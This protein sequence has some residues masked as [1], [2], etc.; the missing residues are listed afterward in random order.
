MSVDKRI[1][2]ICGHRKSGT[3]MFVNLFDGHPELAVFPQDAT[4]LYAYH[5]RWL[6]ETYSDRDRRERLEQV[7]CRFFTVN[8]AREC[9]ASGFDAN[10]FAARF[11]AALP[12]SSLRDM[13]A[14][15]N[16]L[17]DAYG[18]TA[19]NAERRWFVLKET[20]VELMAAELFA[21]F[22]NSRFIQLMRDPRDNYGALKSGVEK[23]YGRFGEDEHMTLSSL[24][25]RA[26]LGMMFAKANAARFGANRYKVVRFEDL[27]RDSETVL[28]DV[29][30]FLG[31]A[32]DPS[33][34]VPTVLGQ[35]TRGNS[36]EKIDFSRVS[37]RNVGRWRTRISPEEAAVIEFNFGPLMEEFGYVRETSETARMDAASA[38][39]KWE[40]DRYHYRDSFVGR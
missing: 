23:H 33:L 9:A 11:R 7:V 37:D 40:N 15:V 25:H 1:V 19:G 31:I 4:V 28:N 27:V 18:A 21:A 34:L 29:C 26:R 12:D 5:P 35:P 16:A 36:Y 20:S 2:F 8:L 14:I 30:G 38:F 32:F 39:Y 17:L 13:G 24:M 6:G 22:P 3:T 10:A